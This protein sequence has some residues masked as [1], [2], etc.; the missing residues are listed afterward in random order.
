MKK[1]SVY[2][3]GTVMLVLLYIM[4]KWLGVIGR[5]FS[6]G[7]NTHSQYELTQ[8]GQLFELPINKNMRGIYRYS[9]R[10]VFGEIDYAPKG[11]YQNAKFTFK[12]EFCENGRQ[13]GIS[14]LRIEA[15][16]SVATHSGI[17]GYG[18]LVKTPL[19]QK[20]KQVCLKIK[21]DE[22]SRPVADDLRLVVWVSDTRP[23]WG[24]ECMLD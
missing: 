19:S 21:V 18:A 16:P 5:Q 12:E 20:H 4:L 7:R 3:S 22:L 8:A 17:G 14:S 13:L 9:G 10:L 11:V 6:D 15:K 1:T 2:F 24:L 23:C